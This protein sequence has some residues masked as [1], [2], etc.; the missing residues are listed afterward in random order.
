MRLNK[1]QA[2]LKGNRIVP[3]G[4]DIRLELFEDPLK[5]LT[6]FDIDGVIQVQLGSC[7][8]LCLDKSL[9]AKDTLLVVKYE[10]SEF[11]AGC[12]IWNI[13]TEGLG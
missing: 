12:S 13:T 9:D 3:N 11:R 10:A 7:S 8:G 4:Q 1:L 6:S 5:E 2:N